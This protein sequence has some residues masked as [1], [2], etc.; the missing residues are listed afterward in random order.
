MSTVKLETSQGN[1]II[2]LEDEG[3]ITVKNFL[4]SSLMAYIENTIFHRVIKGFMIQGGGFESNMQ[5]QAKSY[6]Q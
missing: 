2:E 1:I 3:P 5:K 6:R 4:D